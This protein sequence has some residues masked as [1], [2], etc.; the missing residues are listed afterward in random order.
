MN[1]QP[2]TRQRCLQWNSFWFCIRMCKS[3]SKSW[4]WW[5]VPFFW[6]VQ[7]TGCNSSFKRSNVVSDDVADCQE[8]IHS[9]RALS[10]QTSDIWMGCCGGWLNAVIS[11]MLWK[12]KHVVGRLPFSSC[13][14]CVLANISANL[15]NTKR[16][17]QLHRFRRVKAGPA[18]RYFE[19]KLPSL[20]PGKRLYS[21]LPPFSMH[22]DPP[23]TLLFK[24][25]PLVDKIKEGQ[26]PKMKRLKRLEDPTN[27]S[28][29]P[30]PQDNEASSADDC[31][32]FGN[33]GRNEGL[34]WNS[35][36]PFKPRNIPSNFPLCFVDFW[37][38]RL[39]GG[40][41]VVSHNANTERPLLC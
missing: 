14:S 31:I 18:N 38:L 2:M 25:G 20:Q 36:L 27:R 28:L 6:A 35:R 15:I 13:I 8:H 24:L 4:H 30:Q 22:P 19:R 33:D 12:S 1:Q 16:S 7:F 10:E 9:I 39:G 17:L 34:I 32:V 41:K 37:K 40:C 26:R 3:R 23:G 11:L 29:P 5:L 21:A